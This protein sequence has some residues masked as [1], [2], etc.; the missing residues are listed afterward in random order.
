MKRKKRLTA[1]K[2]ENAAG[3]VE[4]VVHWMEGAARK[5]IIY[6]AEVIDTNGFKRE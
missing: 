1:R 4:I 2:E 3:H 5:G 6:V